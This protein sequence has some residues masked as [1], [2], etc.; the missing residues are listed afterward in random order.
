[1]EAVY[2]KAIVGWKV[3]VQKAARLASTCV[4]FVTDRGPRDRWIDRGAFPRH[5]L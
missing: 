3:D 2:P 1:M 4:Y 5:L